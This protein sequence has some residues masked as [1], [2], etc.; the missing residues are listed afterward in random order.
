[1][2]KVSI[3]VASVA[4]AIAAYLF[5]PDNG[6]GRR[7]RAMDQTT[8]ALDSLKG[9]SAAQARH[10]RNVVEGWAHEIRGAMRPSRDFD[11]G[12]LVQKVRSE[13][14][15]AWTAQGHPPV[16]VEASDGYIILT[17]TE[18]DPGRLEELLDRVRKVEGVE[19]AR[20]RPSG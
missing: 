11:D 3:V 8:A 10:Q 13:V 5:D 16:E 20:Y 4:G 9:R 19:D 15:G 18:S 7:A 12:T 2:R 14:I 6:R 1:M 17:T